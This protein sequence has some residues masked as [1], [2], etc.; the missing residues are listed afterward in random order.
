VGVSYLEHGGRLDVIPVLL[1]EGVDGLLAL[2]LLTLGKT[3]VLTARQGYGSTRS[4]K[5]HGTMMQARYTGDESHKLT[6]TVR[7]ACLAQLC[8]LCPFVDHTYFGAT[9]AAT[10][11]DRLNTIQ[12]CL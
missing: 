1:G 12:R 6:V 7:G 3:L 10:G 2:T 8:H 5:Q 11:N 9:M 4:G